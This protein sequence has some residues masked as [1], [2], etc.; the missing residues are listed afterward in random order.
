MTSLIEELNSTHGGPARQ[1][2][3]VAAEEG[4][5]AVAF[6]E[7]A[8]HVVE[9]S[10]DGCREGGMSTFGADIPISEKCL[11]AEPASVALDP[12]PAPGF[13]VHSGIAFDLDATGPL[14]DVREDAET[15]EAAKRLREGRLGYRAF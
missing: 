10:E 7:S 8:L 9:V 13:T 1:G 3:A 6:E 12:D 2:S 5:L 4:N 11:N 15:L 14:P